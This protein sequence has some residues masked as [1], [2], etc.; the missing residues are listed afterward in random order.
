MAD[1]TYFQFGAGGSFLGLAAYPD[2]Y[3]VNYNPN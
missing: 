1:A 3:T 2:G